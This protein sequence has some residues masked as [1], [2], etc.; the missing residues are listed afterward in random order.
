MSQ[1]AENRA[2][3]NRR[4]AAARR[5]HAAENRKYV[6]ARREHCFLLRCEGLTYKEIGA[7]VGCGTAR[8]YDV[9]RVFTNRIKRATKRTRWRVT[10][11]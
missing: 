5:E 4:R 2:A 10:G 8:A 3:E 11:Y 1:A 6:A 7:R 9:V